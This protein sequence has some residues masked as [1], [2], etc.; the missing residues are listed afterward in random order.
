MR[1]SSISYPIRGVRV[2]QIQ[3]TR[4][5]CFVRMIIIRVRVVQFVCFRVQPA[6]T[7]IQVHRMIIT[8]RPAAAAIRRRLL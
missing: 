4:F 1:V 2:V 8:T 3:R 7:R 6:V 5:S